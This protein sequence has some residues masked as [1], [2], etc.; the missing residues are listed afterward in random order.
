MTYLRLHIYYFS[1]N[2]DLFSF[3]LLKAPIFHQKLPSM[4]N[5]AI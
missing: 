2:L 4:R 3:L 5:L 1:A